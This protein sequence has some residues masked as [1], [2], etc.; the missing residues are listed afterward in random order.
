M[1]LTLCLLLVAAVRAEEEEADS[2]AMEPLADNE[3]KKDDFLLG[4]AAHAIHGTLGAAHG[5]VNLAGHILLGD[6]DKNTQVE[7]QDEQAP[8]DDLFCFF[9]RRRHHRRRRRHHHHC[10]NYKK[11]YNQC[12]ANIRN[13]NIHC[14]RRVCGVNTQ[15][16]KLNQQIAVTLKQIKYY[17]HRTLVCRRRCPYIAVCPGRYRRRRRLL[18]QRRGDEEEE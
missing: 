2:T 17:K 18:I 16:K 6:E 15:I 11:S 5:A 10:N 12:R 13:T 1:G 4:L 8:K 14:N 7:Q 3:E 9:R